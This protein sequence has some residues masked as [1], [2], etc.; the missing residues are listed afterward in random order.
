MY[1]SIKVLFFFPFLGRGLGLTLGSVLTAEYGIRFTYL[2]FGIFA[3]VTSL[4]Y[5]IVYHLFLRKIEKA[6]LLS[7][8]Q[9]LT[10]ITVLSVSNWNM[11]FYCFPIFQSR[12]R[13]PSRTQQVLRAQRIVL[14]IYLINCRSIVSPI[15]LL[16]SLGC[17]FHP[18]RYSHRCIVLWECLQVIANVFVM[19][20]L[21]KPSKSFHSP[22][23]CLC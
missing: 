8:N 19:A 9:S 4:S 23:Y 17:N 6:R 21:F 11:F 20:K 3:G 14:G 16:R 7:A 1:S 22:A 15:A 18:H 12:M 2:V 13:R 10:F 5:I